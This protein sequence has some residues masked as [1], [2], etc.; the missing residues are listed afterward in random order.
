MI[1][2]QLCAH[3]FCL[4]A[5][6]FFLASVSSFGPTM[7]KGDGC[8][9]QRLARFFF[10]NR[11]A[12]FHWTQRLDVVQSLK[13]GEWVN[14][15]ICICASAKRQLMCKYTPSKMQHSPPPPTWWLWAAKQWLWA[16]LQ[17]WRASL[18][19]TFHFHCLNS[20]QNYTSTLSILQQTHKNTDINIILT[21][22]PQIVLD[23]T[24]KSSPVISA[25]V[26]SGGCTSRL[27][28]SSTR[29]MI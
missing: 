18:Y 6:F 4:L 15:W 28:P 3:L 2:L 17:P 25:N 11:T 13:E 20:A 8:Q 10:F 24:C 14:E 19:S 29:D 5:F 7:W 21:P 1:T 22:A 9:I 16:P 27:T 12:K 26:D 23:P